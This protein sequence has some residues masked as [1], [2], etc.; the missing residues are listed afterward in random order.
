LI[1]RGFWR[2]VLIPDAV[3]AVFLAEPA[4]RPDTYCADCGTVFPYR[5]GMWHNTET[6]QSCQGPLC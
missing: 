5:M 2:P 4:A 1:W 3:P 6:G